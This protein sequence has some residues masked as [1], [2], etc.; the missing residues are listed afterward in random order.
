MKRLLTLTFLLAFSFALVAEAMEGPCQET[1]GAV[2]CVCL[3]H[4][5]MVKP[6]ASKAEPIARSA[7]FQ[8]PQ[9]QLA[10]QLFDKS[11]FHPPAALA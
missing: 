3:C 8:A 4:A 10:K 11:F 7:H 9:A 2:C 6:T 5:P 1:S